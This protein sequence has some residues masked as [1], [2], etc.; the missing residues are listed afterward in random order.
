MD[1]DT[2]RA[3]LKRIIEVDKIAESLE[4]IEDKKNEIKENT[5]SKVEEIKINTEAKIKRFKD[6]NDE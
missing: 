1:K 5:K 4:K 3:I 2:E 6:E